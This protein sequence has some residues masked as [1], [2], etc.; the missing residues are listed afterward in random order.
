MLKKILPNKICDVLFHKLNVEHIYEIRLRARRP[1]TVNYGGEFHY[2]T[3]GGYSDNSDNAIIADERMLQDVVVRASDYSLYT[4]NRNI[5]DGFIT[6]EGGIRIGIAG[7]YVWDN[8]QLKT[9]KNFSGLTIRIPHE[10]KGCADK[11][12]RYFSESSIKNCLIMSPPACGKTTIL[13]DLCRQLGNSKPRANILLIDERSE[14]AASVGGIPQLDVG[15][16]VDVLTGCTKQSGM[17]NAILS[18]KPY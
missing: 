16:N 17:I 10:I 1:I 12:M 13:R 18:M 14:I 6:I 7:E 9:I 5:C 15:T 3:S 8:D 11:L 4:V 2:L